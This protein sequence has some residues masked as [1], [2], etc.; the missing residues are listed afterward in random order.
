MDIK[1]LYICSDCK[2]EKPIEN[3]SK[4]KTSKRGLQ[5][6]CKECEKLY[7]LN[8]HE[9]IL[10][11]KRLN[12]LKNKEKSKIYSKI[13]KIKNKDKIKEQKRIYYL[14]NKNH[15]KNRQKQY[16]LDN[17][18]E[19]REYQRNYTR[20]KRANNI[21]FKIEHRLR[22]RILGA[23]KKQNTTK[24]NSFEDLTGG[25]I[26]FL[27]KHIESQF[28]EGMTWDKFMI[29]EIVIDHIKPCC[30]FDFSQESQQK[31]CF[32]YTNLRPMW[33]LENANKISED[34][35]QRLIKLI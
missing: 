11:R 12:Y 26:D 32:H 21:H 9:R 3:F 20:N 14:N 19:Y 18:D 31:E 24:N 6:K 7:T 27:K 10:K 22:N 15:I 8:N 13:W 25:S 29:G 1:P 16:R 28:T 4:C 35:K 33:K 30:S 34:L 17:L 5:Y 2:I 23:L